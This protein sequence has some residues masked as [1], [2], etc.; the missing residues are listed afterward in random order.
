MRTT[1]TM[2]RCVLRARHGAQAKAWVGWKEAVA[3]GRVQ[4]C[5]VQCEMPCVQVCYF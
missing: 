2:R 1:R 5:G 4:V 3:I